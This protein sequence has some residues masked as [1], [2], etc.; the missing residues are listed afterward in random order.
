MS[1]S[2]IVVGLWGRGPGAAPCPPGSYAYAMFRF[3][4]EP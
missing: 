4:V 1:E 2:Y 3:S